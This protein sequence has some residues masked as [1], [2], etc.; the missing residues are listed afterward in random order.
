MD[1]RLFLKLSSALSASMV[2]STGLSGCA[3][4]HNV[5]SDQVNFTHG[6]AS[7]DPL[8]T[9]VVLWTRAQ[10][11]LSAVSATVRW[12]IASD[13]EFSSIIDQ[14]DV[15]AQAQYDFT[16]K[17]DVQGLAPGQTYYYRFFTRHTI[18]DTGITRTLPK[19]D[20][21]NVTFAVFSCS[22]YPAGYFTPYALAAQDADVDYVLHLGDYI[23][24]Y[25]KGGYATAHADEI[26]RSFAPGN[27]TELYTLAD[28][29][30]RYA[31]YRT[32][33]AL[34]DLH[35]QKPFIVVW[36]DHE[37][38]NDTYKSG[39]KN[40]TPDEGD[41]FARRTAAVQAYYEWLPIRPPQGDTSIQIYRTFEFGSL[42]TLHM[43]DTRVIGRDKQLN[44]ADYKNADTG[45]FDA[46]AFQT[47]LL[48]PQRT[49]LGKEQKA[50]FLSQLQH[51]N[52]HWQ[53][54]G[55]QVLMAKMHFPSA[56]LNSTDRDETE[57][58]IAKL[59]TLQRRADA[60]EA[61]SATEQALLATKMPYNLDAWDGYPVEREMLLNA[62][63]SIGKPV[64]VL[65]GDTHNGWHS[66]LRD[67]Q[68]R[69]AATELGTSSVSSPGMEDYILSPDSDF[70][71]VEKDV[72]VLVDELQ[73]CN[74]HQRGWLKVTFTAKEAEASW[75][76]VDSVTTPVATGAA[77]HKVTITA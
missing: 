40:H 52:A 35:A 39:A 4:E 72:P 38:A 15:I 76:Y 63:I 59:A 61:L 6:V 48:N 64:V 56:V 27:D 51:S 33:Q 30:S 50:W 14:G 69:V 36:D 13:A 49:M 77:T 32:D 55:Q 17:V 58:T 34:L 53:V 73:Y 24:E 47:D 3:T 1:R 11:A 19:K 75:I 66:I 2:V 62:F 25:G 12:Q 16:V 70:D 28:Y 10:P 43:L 74:L 41:F 18:S 37:V 57:K 54:I 45:E 26:G 65:A 8:T 71:A 31:T 7:G 5:P 60:G 23:Y 46:K 42:L 44:Y 20:I 29:R 21:E 22:N 67:Q 68:G 9:A